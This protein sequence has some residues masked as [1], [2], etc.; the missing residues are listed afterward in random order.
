MRVIMFL[1]LNRKIIYTILS[2]F[3]ISS[4]SFIS[5]F[6][7]AYSSKVEKDQIYSIQRNQQYTDLLYRNILLIKELKQLA[8]EYQ[9]IKIDNDLYPQIYSL[10]YDSQRPEFLVNEQKMIEERSK[11]FDAQYKT[12]NNGITIIALS[13]LILALFIIFI[14]YLIQRWILI[15]INKI[16]SISEEISNGNLNIRIPLRSK[17]TYIDELDRLSSTFN[18]MVDNLQNTLSEVRNKEKF[19][20]SLIDSIPD[21]IRVIDQNYNIIIAN[22][23]YYKQVGHNPHKKY[24]CYRSAFKSKSPC[25]I[26]HI[27]CPLYEITQ[28]N[29]KNVN[30]IQQ[31]SHN[32]KRHLAINAAPLIYDNKHMYIVESIRDLSKDIDFSHQQKISS[33][34]FLSSSIAH[35]IKN[36]LGALRLITE[37][38]IDKYY[39][40]LPDDN[41]Q[42]KMIKMIHSEIIETA[43]VPERLLKLMRNSTP[44]ETLINCIEC[45]NDVINILDFEAKSKGINI[46]FSSPSQNIYI[47]GNETDFKIAVINIILNALK[48][49][50]GDG[51]L[52]ISIED[53]PTGEIKINFTDTGHGI[54][55]TDL[56]YIFNPFFSE[57]RQTNDSRGSGLGLAITKSIIEK[58]GGK[59]NVVSTLGKGSCFTFSFPPIKNL[60]KK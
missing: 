14:G 35:E 13:A 4:I 41:E 46:S 22:K 55:S 60:Q 23:S 51:K 26:E 56:P 8:K 54:S 25:N 12:I 48:A 53:L 43:K 9:G 31:F 16:S 19:L 27:R 2:L 29:K 37:H 1:S 38:T 24:T 11:N 18:M 20:Q 40:E 49:I 3:L 28:K 10:I 17:A 15:P 5:A 30:T 6:Y 58:F 33:L 47:H 57:G 52:S 36:H 45:I 59:I 39:N 50:Q 7:M 21:G 34:G 32:A 44:N 42:K